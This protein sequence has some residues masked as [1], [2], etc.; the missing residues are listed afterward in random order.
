MLPGVGFGYI[1]NIVAACQIKCY[2][3]HLSALHVIEECLVLMSKVKLCKNA[4]AGT[5]YLIH[6]DMCSML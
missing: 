1:L 2:D 3:L 6:T 4:C 5:E